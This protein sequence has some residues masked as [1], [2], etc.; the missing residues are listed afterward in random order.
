MSETGHTKNATNFGALIAVVNGMGAIYNPPVASIEIANLQTKQT[1][2][3]TV[4]TA[5]ETTGA[6]EELAINN[7]QELHDSLDKIVRRFV[8]A[9]EVSIS[10]D[11]FIEDLK[12]DKR[13]FEGRRAGDKPVDD[14]STPD[15]DESQTAH[16]VSQQSYDYR[17]ARFGEMVAKVRAQG[18]YATNEPDLQIAELETLAAN[19]ETANNRVINAAVAAENA[20]NARDQFLYNEND[21]IIELAN[22]VKKYVKS[23]N[24][25]EAYYKQLTALKDQKT[26]VGQNNII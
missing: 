1:G 17:T 21:G 4:L 8:N 24:N 25:A 20:R 11:R 10:D 6:V 2:N 3:E 12:N 14:P 15:I 9:A 16:S 18:D 19:L 5:V 7:R 23:I 13:R 22:L 26:V